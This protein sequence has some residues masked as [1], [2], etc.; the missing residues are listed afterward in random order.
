MGEK[1]GKMEVE[2]R[3]AVEN[4]DYDTAAAKK[5]QIDEFRLQIYRDLNVYDLLEP[6]GVCA[7]SYL[8]ICVE[9]CEEINI[10]RALKRRN[11]C[12]LICY[13]FYEVKIN[14]Q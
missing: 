2:K 12:K 8:F 13:R 11:W 14:V 4:E 7:C 5:V 3:Q 1:L 6:S 9:S 10:D